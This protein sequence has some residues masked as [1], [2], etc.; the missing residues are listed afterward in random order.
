MLLPATIRRD[1]KMLPHP[2]KNALD[3]HLNSH[4]NEVAL[5][6]SPGGARKI[7]LPPETN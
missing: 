2:M 6:W 1:V 5:V 7:H 4:Y 3:I